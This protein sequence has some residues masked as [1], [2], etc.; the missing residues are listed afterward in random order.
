MIRLENVSLRYHQGPEV[1]RNIN[2]DIP[3]GAFRFLTGP[4]GAGKTSLLK[5]DF[6]GP[7]PKPG[8]GL[9]NGP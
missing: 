8:P 3:Q 6:S 5:T 9:F 7:C 4:S 2:L 1:L